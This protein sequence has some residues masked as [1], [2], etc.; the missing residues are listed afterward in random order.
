MTT[1]D[2]KIV[3]LKENLTEGA[4][5][6]GSFSF[7]QQMHN[8][9]VEKTTLEG[10]ISE[11]QVEYIESIYIDA[12][13][14]ID[15]S[16]TF[17]EK[18]ETDPSFK[19]KFETCLIYY[20][21]ITDS[22]YYGADEVA[23]SYRHFL[24]TGERFVLSNG[25]QKMLNNKYF[26]K[27]WEAYTSEPIFKEGSMAII[28]SNAKPIAIPQS[29]RS[30]ARWCK[31]KHHKILARKILMS[32][33]TLEETEGRNNNHFLLKSLKDTPVYVL[34]ADPFIPIS[35]AKGSKLYTVIPL[36]NCS[37]TVMCIEERYLKKY[38]G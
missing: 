27:V 11:R 24:S 16:K 5:N 32:L 28:R 36:D 30:N 22:P 20:N 2:E 23:L 37:K 1:V 34:A 8:K 19:K 35:S 15:F 25:I 33:G 38:R 26:M 10:N 21:F 13:N 18:L 14:L 3:F 4:I 31:V 12:K 7:V 6:H 9:F 17:Y 29:I